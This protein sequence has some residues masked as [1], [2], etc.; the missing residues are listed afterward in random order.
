MNDA[1]CGI[2]IFCLG[3][4][5]GA[6]VTRIIYDDKTIIENKNRGKK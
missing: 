4:I 1:A 2:I 3:W 6:I 5:F